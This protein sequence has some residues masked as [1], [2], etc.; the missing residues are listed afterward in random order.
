MKP[1]DKLRAMEATKAAELEAIRSVILMLEELEPPTRTRGVDRKTRTKKTQGTATRVL[2]ALKAQDTLSAS[3]LAETVGATKQNIYTVISHLRD[4]RLV[5]N[6]PDGSGYR[7]TAHG[8]TA[9]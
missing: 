4:K 9:T 5:G 8:K 6:A 3:Q 7:L 2:L 1:I